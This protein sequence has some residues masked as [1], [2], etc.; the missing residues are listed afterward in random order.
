MSS[1]HLLRWHKGG[2]L[3]CARALLTGTLLISSHTLYR[4]YSRA[5]I[6]CPY[7]DKATTAVTNIDLPSH[8]YAN[9]SNPLPVR[10]LYIIGTLLIRHPSIHPSTHPPKN[11]FCVKHKLLVAFVSLYTFLFFY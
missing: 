1:T 7:G 10:R 5:R 4:H 6:R 2:Q 8:T 11:Q 9:V 3:S